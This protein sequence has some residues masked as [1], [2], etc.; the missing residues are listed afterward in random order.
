MRTRTFI[1]DERPDDE[2]FGSRE[3]IVLT[4]ADGTRIDHLLVKPQC[5]PKASILVFHGSG[6]KASNWLKLL[7]PLVE[8]GYQIFLMDYRG[9]G[10]SEGHATH[11]KVLEDANGALR[12][13]IGREDVRNH[14]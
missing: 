11:D 3:R 8:N 9:F 5:E 12:H 2:I 14:K 10:A 7:R 1:L 13:L 6:S 4:S